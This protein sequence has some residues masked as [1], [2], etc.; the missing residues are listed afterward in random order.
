LTA[1]AVLTAAVC[2][3]ESIASAQ[4][5]PFTNPWYWAPSI[6]AYRYSQG[7]GYGRGYGYGGPFSSGYDPI[8]GSRMATAEMI[9]AAGQATQARS[10]ALLNYEQARSQYIENADRWTDVYNKRQRQLQQVQRENAAREAYER[11]R[12]KSDLQRY[13]QNRREPA[14]PQTLTPAQL[15]PSTGDIE[16]PQ[17]LLGE[18]YALLRDAIEREYATLAQTSGAA[19]NLPRIRELADR[20]R[21]LLRAHIGEM[22]SYEYIAARKFIDGLANSAAAL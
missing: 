17:V 4:V 3:G 14:P 13:L 19:G 1:T 20:M 15:N 16:W 2:L 12:K 9:R 21:D 22:P 7:Y 5:V 10:Q 11:E 6:G 18:E 8:T